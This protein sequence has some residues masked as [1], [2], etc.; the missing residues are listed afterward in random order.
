MHLVVEIIGK[1]SLDAQAVAVAVVQR[2]CEGLVGVHWNLGQHTIYIVVAMTATG[3]V[4]TVA[5]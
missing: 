4:R 1:V 3:E 5:A 2:E